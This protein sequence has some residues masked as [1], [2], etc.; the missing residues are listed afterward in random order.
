MTNVLIIVHNK[1]ENPMVLDRSPRV[2]AHKDIFYRQLWWPFCSAE[3]NCLYN[4]GRWHHEEH[5]SG[6]G[7]DVV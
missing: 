7:E 1:Q 2:L 6:S 4:S 3:Q 5:S